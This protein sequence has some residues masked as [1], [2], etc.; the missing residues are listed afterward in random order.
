MIKA[1]RLLYIVKL[2]EHRAYTTAELAE[3]CDV[4]QRTIQQDIADL[5]ADPLFAPLICRTRKEWVM[6]KPACDA[7]EPCA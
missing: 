4:S 5:Q 3:Q 7:N 1:I 6:L 2:L